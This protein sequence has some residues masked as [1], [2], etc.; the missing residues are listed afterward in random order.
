M[1]G[2]AGL[3]TGRRPVRLPAMDAAAAPPRSRS[4]YQTESAE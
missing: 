3:R 2:S 1:S 4:A